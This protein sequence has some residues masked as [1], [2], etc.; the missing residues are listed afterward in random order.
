MPSV[1]NTDVVGIIYPPPE[2]RTS[3]DSKKPDEVENKETEKKEKI[4]EKPIPKEPPAFEFMAELPAI[5]AQDLD[6]LKL[7]AQFVAR[8]GRQFMT[9]LAQREQRN[10]QFE[11]LRPNHS[12]FNYFTKLV[13]Q[14]TKVLIPSKKLFQNLEINMHDKYTVLDRALQRVEYK[15]YQEEQKKKEE[16]KADAEKIAYA[17]IDWHDFVIVDTI[18]FTEADESMDLPPPMSLSELQHMSLIQKKANIISTNELAKKEEEQAGD[19]DMDEEMDMED[20]THKQSTSGVIQ[21]DSNAPIK[22]RTD[23]TPKVLKHQLEQQTQI[24]PRCGQ[25][26][27][28]SEMDEHVRIELLDPKWREQKKISEAKKKDSNLLQTGIDVAA[29]LNKLSGYRTDIFGS[30]E[31]EIGKK[32]EEDAEKAKQAEKEKV[33][34]D[35]HIA[36]I[37]SATRQ[38]Q[39]T[40]M[41]IDEQ[42]A[43]IYRRK[44]LADEDKSKIGPQMP[45]QKVVP[46][47]SLPIVQPPGIP[48]A[49]GLPIPPAA[50]NPG[51]PPRPNF[52]PPPNPF[53]YQQQQN[54]YPPGPS[55]IR[56]PHMQQMPS[57]RPPM[58]MHNTIPPALPLLNNNYPGKPVNK[59]QN[60]YMPDPKRQRTDSIVPPPVSSIPPPPMGNNLPPPPPPASNITVTIQTTVNTDKPEWGLDG[61]TFTVPDVQPNDTVSTLK[62]RISQIRNM[63]AGRQKLSMTSNGSTVLLKNSMTITSYGINEGVVLTLAVKERGGRK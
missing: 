52:P 19:M 54:M 1:E 23:Y 42:I 25:A 57:N 62:E 35:G 39:Q 50:N 13:E 26:I 44:G 56:P 28:V 24:C 22:I 41:S 27:P 46:P 59:E 20:E 8:N 32:I 53:L 14:Y 17:S 43:A 7:T 38:A 61:Q 33:I 3:E 10:Y 18:E 16:E 11:F 40:G 29:N 4:P 5:S 45:E 36:S 34:W 37:G 31:V 55:P 2:I 15:T 47:P 58:M 63:P 60:M 49:P 30:E 48:A 6:I 12:L 51:I 9:G 21:I